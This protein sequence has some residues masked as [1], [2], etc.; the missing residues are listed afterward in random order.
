M[1]M[2][3]CCIIG[4]GSAAIAC[5]ISASQQ[6]IEN[7]LIIEREKE[8]GG[9]LNQC[10]HNG[11]GLHVLKKECTGPEYAQIMIDRLKEHKI[12]I[13]TST[14]VMNI[15]E[16]KTI[17][18]V[19]ESGVLKIQAESIVLAGGCYERNRGAIA[20]S[21]DRCS[22]IFCAG[23]AQKYLNM[24]GYLCGKKV[25]IL[26]SGDIGLIM[27]RRLTL[28]GATV[29]GVAEIMPYSNGLKRNIVQCLE[30]F[31]IPLYLST[32]VH[33][34]MGKKRLEKIELIQVDENRQPI[35]G[36]EWEVEADCLL[37]SVGLLPET[38]LFDN[39]GLEKDLRT[40]SFAVDEM[41]QCS[42]EG[43][44]IC[45]NAL[46]VHDLVD[47]VSIEG[48][49]CGKHVAGYLKNKS[50]KKEKVNVTAGN[51]ISYVVPQ[52]LH[53]DVGEDVRFTMRVKQPLKNKVIA[54]LKDGQLIHEVK[55]AVLLPSEMEAIVLK[56]ELLG[57]IEE[58]LQFEV[59]DA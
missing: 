16:D 40:K 53:C 10:I 47:Y 32:T 7:I 22:G 23:T 34:V 19:N 12:E 18:A 3:D 38:S 59:R 26:G 15:N 30:D 54:V 56:K 48:E 35:M 27:A 39:L 29:L 36:S 21:G 14:N 24:E 43:F 42:K 5:A 57:H 2:V 41:Y 55:K 51:E 11:F 8:L 44:F 13:L 49:A 33:R 50:F 58:N 4:G 17:D 20:I 37:L 9:I 25:F 1:R 6:G 31:N 28:E 52:Y 45:G 46:Q